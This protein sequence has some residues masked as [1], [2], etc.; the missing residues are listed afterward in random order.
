MRR[1]MSRSG[2]EGGN[3]IISRGAGQKGK[4]GLSLI[5]RVEKELERMGRKIKKINTY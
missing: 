2:N 4:S 5:V 1:D 3:Q